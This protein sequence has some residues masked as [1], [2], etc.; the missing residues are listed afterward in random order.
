MVADCGVSGNNIGHQLVFQH[1]Y[2]IAQT[3]L[4]LFKAGQLH[5]VSRPPVDQGCD[6]IVQV[7]MLY[8]QQLQAAHDIFGIHRRSVSTQSPRH[9]RTSGDDSEPGTSGPSQIYG[10][11]SQHDNHGETGRKIRDLL[12][13]PSPS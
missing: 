2:F 10:R 11:S 13:H 3:Q 4:A 5:L 6:R 8:P 1:R 7:T 12:D 9:M